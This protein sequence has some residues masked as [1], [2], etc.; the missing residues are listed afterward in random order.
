M[1]FAMTFPGLPIG[2]GKTC[3]CAPLFGGQLVAA[4]NLS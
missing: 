3:S 4:A 1:L 2:V